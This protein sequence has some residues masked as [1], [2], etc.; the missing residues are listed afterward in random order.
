MIAYCSL[1]TNKT[2]RAE[3]AKYGWRWIVGPFAPKGW[4]TTMGSDLYALDNGAWSCHQ[5]G[6]PFD[7]DKFQA[8]VDS[9]GENADW[10]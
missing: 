8:A 5:K 7:T 2:T 1:S 4:R 9:H 3:L 10:V 6:I